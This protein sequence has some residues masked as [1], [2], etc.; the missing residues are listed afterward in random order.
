[1]QTLLCDLNS[2]TNDGNFIWTQ[3]DKYTLESQLILATCQPLCLNPSPIV[4][5]V[6][7][8]LLTHKH[9]LNDKYLKRATQRFSHSYLTNRQTSIDATLLPMPFH[10]LKIRQKFNHS[11]EVSAFHKNNGAGEDSEKKLCLNKL[12]LSSSKIRIKQHQKQELLRQ[13]ILF[14]KI[15]LFYND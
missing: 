15:K 10:I 12:P 3:E 5:L 8:R 2:I 13:R 11:D 14:V 9:K 4:S 6:K 1:M 7:N